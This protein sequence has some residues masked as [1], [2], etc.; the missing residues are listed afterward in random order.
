M[1]SS[2]LKIAAVGTGVVILAIGVGFLGGKTIHW[3]R[4]AHAPGIQGAW[5]G[6]FD[7]RAVINKT[8]SI[9]PTQI[10]SDVLDRLSDRFQL[11]LYTGRR[12]YEVPPT[13]QRFAFGLTFDPIVTAEMVGRLKPAPDGLKL[14]VERSPHEHFWYV[15]YAIDDCRCA[16][17][18]E[19]PFIGIA[20]PGSPRH[21]KLVS[22]FR[23]EG[24][25]AVLDDINQLEAVL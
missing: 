4:A 19:V 2:K 13:L 20:A 10:V 18:A 11:A 1:A 5:A 8:G 14:I 12:Q 9:V 15:G 7:G 22:L 23:D 25:I 17:A 21:R 24:A 16:R 3:V 6:N